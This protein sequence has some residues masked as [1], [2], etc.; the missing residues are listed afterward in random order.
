MPLGCI[1]K[2]GGEIKQVKKNTKPPRM[3]VEEKRLVRHMALEKGML[4]KDIAAT[5]GWQSL[6][7]LRNDNSKHT[8]PNKT[9]DLGP[10]HR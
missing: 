10:A 6:L 7:D 9:Q 2:V 5:V 8:P 1:R 3:T 4:P